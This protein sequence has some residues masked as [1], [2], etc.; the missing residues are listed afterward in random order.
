MAAVKAN[1]SKDKTD[2]DDTKT[3]NNDSNQDSKPSEAKPSVQIQE[4]LQVQ[5]VTKI[6][7]A[8]MQCDDTIYALPSNLDPKSLSKVINHILKITKEEEQIQFDFL[9][10]NEY[11]FSSL[12]THLFENE[13]SSEEKLIIEYIEKTIEPSAKASDQHPDWVSC[14]DALKN[15][16]FITGCY[17]GIIRCWKDDEQL[18]TQHRGHIAPIKGITALYRKQD[19][20]YFATVAK[21]RSTK[22]F[23]LN[24]KTK[25]ISQVSK[26]E[27][28]SHRHSHRFAVDCC[29][30]PYP[31]KVF[32]TGS[33]DRE[34][35]IYRMTN[36]DDVELDSFI[37][38]GADGNEFEEGPP[39][40]KRKLNDAQIDADTKMEIEQ[41]QDKNEYEGQYE[42]N[43][44]GRCRLLTISTLR[45]HQG[46]VKCVDWDNPFALY[47]GSWDNCIKLWDVHKEIDS[48]T[49]YTQSGVNCIRYWNGQNVLISA[50]ANQKIA[51][52]DP[53]TD[54]IKRNKTMS[55]M[56]F[57]SHR[58]P[59][60]D[61]DVDGMNGMDDT[62]DKKIRNSDYLFVTSSHDGKLKIWDIRS[63]SPLYTIEKHK[64]KVLCV[65]WYG[66]TIISGGSD[67]KLRAFK[68][69]RK[70]N[71]P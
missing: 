57:R 21:D 48:Y 51:I 2:Q 24:E 3:S 19:I 58:L 6:A 11:I 37:E 12:A 43:K 14:L 15:D 59:I 28:A 41:D 36:K 38:D 35:R 29:S 23:C 53:R 31:S 69:T 56:T 27:I 42:D 62:N 10:N 70:G 34:I 47:S 65:G 67:N 25:Q 39:T 22:V 49:W 55:V 32:A 61:I 44:V 50:H 16:L 54:Q 64:G 60:T 1:N 5:F 71:Q 46:A 30:A 26:V 8:A 63:K 40:K 68:W 20:H 52:W 13:I 17:D 45:G 7:D 66:N 18:F 33:A 4:T 9:L